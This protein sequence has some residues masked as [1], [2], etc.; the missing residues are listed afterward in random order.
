MGA[1][2]EN[3][4]KTSIAREARSYLYDNMILNY[5]VFP[6]P[7]SAFICFTMEKSLLYNGKGKYAVQ[8][9]WVVMVRGY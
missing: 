6:S 7:A 9:A 5:L 8:A 4:L 1:N 2:F 3:M